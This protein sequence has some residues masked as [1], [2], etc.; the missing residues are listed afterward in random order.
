M[1][2]GSGDGWWHLGE[3]ERRSLER[4]H[5]V[6]SLLVGLLL[7][8]GQWPKDAVELLGITDVESAAAF[9]DGHGASGLA[10][11]ILSMPEDCDDHGRVV[12]VDELSIGFHWKWVF[13]VG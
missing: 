3:P 13:L 11:P 9:V 5:V 8:L 10:Y 7:R 4:C 6:D 1:S 2:S 12:D